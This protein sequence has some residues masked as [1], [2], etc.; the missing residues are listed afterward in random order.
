[1]LLI[2]DTTQNN[3]IEIGIKDKNRFVIKKKFACRRMQAEK[4]LASIEKLLKAVKLKLGDLKK[5]EVVNRGGGF[6]SL[7]AGV[8][9]A[10][11]LGYALG[12]PVVESKN[13]KV[14][15]NQPEAGRPW[16]EKSRV[17]NS[18]FSVVKPQYDKEAV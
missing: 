5:I 7:R 11:A 4:L 13:L 17:K 10:N 6:T 8:V 9:T 16:A 12:V 18:K 3:F 14:R 1:M 2:I 15:S